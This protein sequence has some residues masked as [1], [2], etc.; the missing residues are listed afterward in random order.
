MT[1]PWSTSFSRHYFQSELHSSWWIAAEN[2]LQIFLSYPTREKKTE[3][4][5]ML[6]RLSFAISP[7]DIVFHWVVLIPWMTQNSIHPTIKT[8]SVYPLL[9]NSAGKLVSQLFLGQVKQV[10][11]IVTSTKLLTLYRRIVLPTYLKFGVTPSSVHLSKLESKAFFLISTFYWQ[12]LS[13]AILHLFTVTGP[14]TLVSACLPSLGDHSPLDI[15]KSFTPSCAVI[16][17]TSRQ[18][19]SVFQSMPYEALR[20]FF[21]LGISPTVNDLDSFRKGVS[22]HLSSLALDFELVCSLL[23]S[24]DQP[25]WALGTS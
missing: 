9:V 10:Q 21:P 6:P 14:L 18:V 25:L 8:F 23:F 16:F 19:R 2:Q 11:S 15:L 22:R 17:P 13:S 5:W 3:R 24:L 7:L 1:L 20:L 4:L 12:T